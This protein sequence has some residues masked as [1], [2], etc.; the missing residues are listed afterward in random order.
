MTRYT[1]DPREGRLYGDGAPIELTPKACALLHLLV[2]RRGLLVTKAEIL[3]R[4]WP[5][6]AVTEASIKDYVKHLRR[7]LDDVAAVPRHIETLRGRG[8]RYIGDVELATGSGVSTRGPTSGPVVAVLP[9]EV[10]RAAADDAEHLGRGL[11]EDI[12]F[13][14]SAYRQLVVISHFS[15][16]RLRQ[17]DPVTAARQLGA[18]YL[19]V[20]SIRPV[21]RHV[22]LAVQLLDG[23]RGQQLWA[24][25]FDAPAG[26]IGDAVVQAI[27]CRL[28]GQVERARTEEAVARSG[29]GELSAYERVLL[30]RFQLAAGHQADVL[31]ARA[32][33][34]AT[35]EEFPAF[36]PAFRWLAETWYDEAC[37]PWSPDPQK[38]ALHAFAVGRRAVEL[39]DQ[40]SGAHLMVAWGY[41]RT[42]R[43]LELA[44]A[45][46]ER[47]L[48]LNPNDY[49]TLCLASAL[50][51][52]SGDLDAAVAHGEEA[53]R[54]SP[55]APDAC[56]RTTGLAHYC[57]G[58][59]GQ[60]LEALSRIKAPGIDVH[61]AVAACYARRGSLEQAAAA[62]AI[63]R[64]AIA[65]A[66][67]AATSTL[68][69]PARWRSYWTRTLPF[70][71]PAHL[72]R[73]LD[74]LAVA[75]VP[76]P[77]TET[78]P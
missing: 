74:D 25:R 2:E 11:C 27:V 57:A 37:S 40:D 35:T 70:R 43:S 61:A 66:G 30:G 18:N 48:A 72:D 68:E 4:I 44:T 32:I 49:Y 12:L 3:A 16:F 77:G 8:Y 51:L 67:V 39:D 41:F 19:V 17:V 34:A 62:A 23:E 76:P 6:T 20:G 38:A 73:L 36:A 24:D 69:D 64:A 15:S 52:W 63:C 78:P 56:S 53:L 5:D 46:L 47:A 55:L 9:F 50:S 31:A 7:A 42:Q 45:Q 21:D 13:G 28:V 60:A 54:R 1:L 71:D 22:R 65:A 33:L 29:A 58:R 59:F 26:A 75:G 14:L 10:E